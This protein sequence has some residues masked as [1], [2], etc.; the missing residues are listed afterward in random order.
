MTVNNQV[1][2]HEEQFNFKHVFE[3]EIIKLFDNN[4]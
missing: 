4:Y 3:Y 1:L 2:K